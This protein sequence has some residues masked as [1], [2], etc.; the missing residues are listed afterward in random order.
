MV[1]VRGGLQVAAAG[2]AGDDDLEAIAAAIEV[3]AV[4]AVLEAGYRIG[5]TQLPARASGADS[6]YALEA[7]PGFAA[8]AAVN[9]ADADRGW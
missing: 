1:V 5:L 2:V 9:A 6:P 4:D 7:I 8:S 3:K